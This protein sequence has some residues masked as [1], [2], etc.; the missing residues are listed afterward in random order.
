M[1]LIKQESMMT[2]KAYQ[3]LYQ[4]SIAYGIR[5]GLIAE[6]EKKKLR[7][8]IDETDEKNEK[9]AEDIEKLEKEIEQLIKADEEERNE[10][11]EK[12]RQEVNVKEDQ[13]KMLKGEIK[14]KW[15]II[16]KQMG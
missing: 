16:S 3:E 13:I 11:K 7:E 8:K 14:N 1:M 12:H 9:I 4:S 15:E 6:E 10:I 5:N 2:M